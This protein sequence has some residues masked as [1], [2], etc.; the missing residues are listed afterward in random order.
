VGVLRQPRQ[1]RHFINIGAIITAF[2]TF[3]ITAAV[4]Y[5]VFIGP[6]KSITA[7]RAAK[8]VAVK[9]DPTEVDLLVQIRDLL[10]D[11]TV[12]AV[13]IAKALSSDDGSRAV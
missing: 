7:R 5:F 8:K 4:V 1:A 6:M 9:A 13:L 2:I 10:R 12:D 11:G 3:L